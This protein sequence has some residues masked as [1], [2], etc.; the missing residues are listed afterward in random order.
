MSMTDRQSLSDLVIVVPGITGS[1]LAIDSVPVWSLSG[2]AI[3]KGVVS[4][5][6]S[7]ERLTLP[8]EVGSCFPENPGDGEPSDHVT[9]TG[10]MPDLHVIPGLW[11]PIKGYS[12]LIKMF[13]SRFAVTVPTN[14]Q[15]GN[16][17]EFPYDWRLS[18]VVSGRRLARIAIP[19]IEQWRRRYPDAKLILVCHSMGGLVARW[20]LEMEGGAEY[21]RWLI[22]VATPYQGSI[23]ALDSL[24]N[25]VSKGLGFL[26]KDLTGLIRTFP[27]MY[28]LLP[29]YPCVD[30]GGTL[31]PLSEVAC[32]IDTDRLAAAAEFHNRLKAR[33]NQ[34]QN[35]P[36][37][38]IAIKGIHQPTAQSA[39][40]T[41]M[42]LEPI[43]T[44]GGLDRSGDG[45]VPRPSAHPPEWIDEQ[46]GP[47]VFAAQRHGTIQ[48][49]ESVLSQLFGQL[50]GRLGTWLG[51]EHL[52]MEIPHL[53]LAGEPV[54][55]TVRADDPTLA[56]R[57]S[58][59]LHDD[60]RQV[61]ASVLMAN[62]GGGRYSATFSGIA[63]GTY[64]AHVASAVASRAIDP[65][66]DI[67][68]VWDPHAA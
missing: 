67:T 41:A 4:L 6:S 50:S 28:E 51:G 13:M 44:Y 64:Q 11:S 55:V 12:A 42:G 62:L 5:G 2:R 8:K 35:A 48:E 10:L 1:A 34:R 26:K 61:I 14:D 17:I 29:T 36:Y 39:R 63:P 37:G 66:F 59:T 23:N 19:A 47:T 22:T 46:G 7:V 18:N 45:T 52:G 43:H 54:E 32:G 65:V 60:T 68:I 31:R 53:V 58:L 49:T 30:E 38:I 16:L 20:F 40:W 3:M 25:G 15:P 27:S 9:A 24:V 56:L 21:T 33:I 57:A